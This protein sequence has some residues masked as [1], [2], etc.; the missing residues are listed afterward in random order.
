MRKMFQFSNAL[1][2][3]SCFLCGS[4]IFAGNGV[5]D[6]VPGEIVLK[7]LPG[8][9]IDS[10]NARFGTITKKYIPQTGNYLLTAQSG[11]DTDS[12]STEIEV[13]NEVEFCDPNFILDAP[14]PVQSSQ[15]FLDNQFIGTYENQTAASTLHL[16]EAQQVTTGSNIMVGVIDG[17]VNISHPVFEGTASYGYDF[18]DGDSIADDPMGGNGS[19]HG[20]FIA[21]VIKLVAPDAQIVSYRVFDTSGRG[22]G[23]SIAE[24]ITLAVDDGCKVINL[25]M[26]MFDKH[27]SI[28][29]ALAYA[30]LHNVLVVAAAG[31]DS[32]TV[33]R[34]PA[35]DSDVLAVAAVDSLNRRADFSNFGGKIDVCAPGI[36]V[37]APFLDTMFAWWNGTSFATPFVAGQ[38]ALLFSMSPNTHRE[39]VR[40]AIINTAIDID[41]WNP[42]LEGELGDGLIDIPS[43]LSAFAPFRCGDMNN[44]GLGPTISDLTYL[45]QFLFGGGNPPQNLVSA[46]VNGTGNVTVADLVYLVGYLFNNGPAPNCGN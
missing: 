31:N 22:D 40:T 37:Y 14:E 2:W 10:V 43:S 28:D 19:G 26:V 30:R 20:T 29:A 36:N 18:V 23:F 13:E 38:A 3:I 16:S 17:G 25:S 12:L 32:S 27:G 45:V 15:P 5:D 35:K 39:A 7:L 4:T 1:V 44:N 34:F 9:N 21:G 24:A 6:K 41:S 33:E 46:D 8:E 42:G 11:Q